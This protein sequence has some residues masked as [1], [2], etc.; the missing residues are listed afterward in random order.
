M[1]LV[2]EILLSLNTTNSKNL[3]QSVVQLFGSLHCPSND[4]KVNW[5][6]FNEIKY[7]FFPCLTLFW[8]LSY[9]DSRKNVSRVTFNLLVQSQL[10]LNVRKS[11]AKNI[12]KDMSSMFFQT[13]PPYPQASTR[14]SGLFINIKLKCCT[15]LCILLSTGSLI[16]SSKQVFLF[17]Y[18][19]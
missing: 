16:L 3:M 4:D 11:K 1:I 13:S 2:D 10:L 6:W 5:E 19:F 9:G 18:I 14:H 7:C 17:T 8:I 15:T 12:K